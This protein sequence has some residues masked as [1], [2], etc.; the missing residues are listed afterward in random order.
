MF[1]VIPNPIPPNKGHL[2]DLAISK[3]GSFIRHCLSTQYRHFLAV[4]CIEYKNHSEP[5]ET[6]IRVT[7]NRNMGMVLIKLAKITN[8][9]IPGHHGT[10]VINPHSHITFR[11]GIP[12][13]NASIL[14]CTDRIANV[15]IHHRGVYWW[16][17]MD[18]EWHTKGTIS[19][20]C[21]RRKSNWSSCPCWYK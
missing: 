11:P 19:I 16:R 2:S 18:S 17:A 13:Q 7:W 9:I 1:S 20:V 5:H 10:I 15:V 8:R 6:R 4:I 21:K 3:R 14:S 12:H